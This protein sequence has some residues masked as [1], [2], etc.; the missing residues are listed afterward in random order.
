M[1][2]RRIR[3]SLGQRHHLLMPCLLPLCGCFHRPSGSRPEKRNK[4][5][6]WLSLVPYNS[7]S[8]RSLLQEWPYHCL[9]RGENLSLRTGARHC[10]YGG[11]FLYNLQ[12]LHL[13]TRRLFCRIIAQPSS[14]HLQMPYTLL[15]E[16]SVVVGPSL[17]PHAVKY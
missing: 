8:R 14:Q 17:P 11:L 4:P 3:A 13:Q 12:I 7:R 5:Y 1:S 16:I 9:K 10:P 6:Q 2:S 15:A